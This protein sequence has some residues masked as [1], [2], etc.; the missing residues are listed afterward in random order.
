MTLTITEPGLYDI[1]ELDYHADKNV[2]GGSFSSSGAKTILKSP[3]LYKWEREHRV[4]KTTYDVGH[5]AHTKILGVGS[6]VIEYPADHLTPSG[7][8]SSK[9]ATVAWATQQ[10]D[11][12]LTPVTPAQIADVDAMAEAVLAHPIARTLLEKPG[13]SEQ[14]LFAPDPETGVWL[15][16]RIDRLP[17]RDS[18]Q[19]LALDLKTSNSANP[20]DFQRSAA[21]YGY[22]IQSEW[23]Q[24]TLN[25]TRGDTDTAFLFIV[26]EKTAPHLV[27]VIELDAEFAAIGRSRMRRAIDLFKAC[28]D[29]NDWPGYEP[30]V[31]LIDSP[32]WLAYEEGM[33]L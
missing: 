6:T 4:D 27:S 15:R 30:I 2:P 9:A 7:N 18:G 28:R 17:D 8:I 31:H 20:R 10:R 29:N 32:R 1:P 25:L 3:A 21:E 19:S 23:Y 11:A 5:A 33:V 13:V 16:A 12:G 26:V 24:H 22:D 14:S